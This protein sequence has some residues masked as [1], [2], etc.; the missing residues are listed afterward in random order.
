M[1]QYLIT[2]EKPLT[3]TVSISGSKNAALPIL[4]AGLLSSSPS[5]LEGIPNLSDTHHMLTLM[6]HMGAMIEK[7]RLFFQSIFF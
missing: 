1:A 5:I 3:G 4:A 7:N 6:E 2:P